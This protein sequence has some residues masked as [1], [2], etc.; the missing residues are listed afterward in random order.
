MKRE[1]KQRPLSNGWLQKKDVDEPVMLFTKSLDLDKLFVVG[2]VQ[3]PYP[4]SE[5]G[6]DVPAYRFR[7]RIGRGGRI[8]FD[9]SNPLLRT[10]I[11]FLF[12]TN[13]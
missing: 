10:V 3:P 11:C 13:Y 9:R 1:L 8:I 2:I 5:D 6:G 12:N 4:T 7:G